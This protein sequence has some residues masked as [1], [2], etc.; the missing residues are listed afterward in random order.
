MSFHIYIRKTPAHLPAALALLILLASIAPP[1]S[2]TAQPLKTLIDSQTYV[3][4]AQSAQPLRGTVRHLTTD[5]YTLKIT[6]DKIVSD[7]PYFGRAY[8]AP[9]DPQQTGIAF[10]SKEFKYTVTPGKRGGWT[11]VIKPKD[12]KDVQE[13]QL[14]ISADGY[15]TV[16]VINSNRDPITF[17]GIVA[18]P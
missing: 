7:L 18:K 14:T 2:A 9:T 12:N 6:K 1:T 5:N 4:Q 10:T 11:V 3:F 8:V 16:Q 15:T 17:N 13:I